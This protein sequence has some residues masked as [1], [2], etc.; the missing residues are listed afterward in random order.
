MPHKLKQAHFHI[1]S[2]LFEELGERLV[3]RPEIALAELIKNSYDADAHACEIEFS[4]QNIIVR[5]NGNGLTETQFLNNW[6]VVSSQEKAAQRYSARY[7]RLMAG[8]KGVGRFSARFLGDH[9]ILDTV[10]Q[11]PK[12]GKKSRLQATFDWTQIARH[13]DLK[14]IVI[15]YSVDPVAQTTKTGATLIVS[16]LRDHVKD[17][18]A[19]RVRTDVLKLVDPSAGLE[20]PN[21]AENTYSRRNTDPGFKV[22][23]QMAGSDETAD[24]NLAESILSA[25][26]GRIRLEVDAQGDADFKVYWKDHTKPLANLKFNIRKYSK[27]FTAKSLRTED[28]ERDNRGLPIVLKD[29]QNLPLATTVGSP[30]FADIRFFPNRKGTFLGLPV[31]GRRA[32][33]WVK[34][35]AGVAIVD[36]GFVVPAYAHINSD[37][38]GIEASKAVNERKWQSIITPAV[39]P[40]TDAEAKSTQLNPMLALPRLSQ[41]VGRIYIT[42]GKPQT[43]TSDDGWLQPNMDRESLRDNGAYRLLWHLVRFGIEAIA[44]FDREVRLDAEE[45]KQERVRQEAKAA[46]AAAIT[47]VK[48]STEISDDHRSIILERLKEASERV[49]ESET[50]ERNSRIALELMSLMGVMARFMTHEFDKALDALQSAAVELKRLAKA[51]PSL[52]K[53]VDLILANEQL[54]SEQAEYMKLFIA[55]SRDPKITS[56]KARA[57]INVAISTLA[58]LAD[59]YGV[60]IKIE[61]DAKLEGPAVP[62]AAYHGVIINLVSNAMKA[63]VASTRTERTVRVIAFS[64]A[65]K[66]VLICADNGVGIPDYLQDR[67]WDPLFTTTHAGNENSPLNSGLGLGLALVRRVVE[68]VNGRIELM[69]TPPPD[70]TTAFRTYLPIERDET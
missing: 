40:M 21:F 69:R 3:S 60:D 34:D 64:E 10:S 67:I 23:F 70:S 45:E 43:G 58:T 2:A 30:I 27:S 50:Y 33:S 49:T 36:H 5:D 47:Q 28:G 55:A 24:T 53:S 52:A 16:R 68:A 15:K 4:D 63:L 44:H 46:L 7:Q 17:L 6:M 1:N 62:L 35:N 66:H 9:L 41:L 48:R 38:L 51:H 56:F 61:A 59:E 57:Q 14:D 18:P 25:Y 37:W 19:D 32:L 42:T 65:G 12:T 20:I 39:Y 8:S 31:H 29:V 22:I 13:K 54:L 26:V 11:H